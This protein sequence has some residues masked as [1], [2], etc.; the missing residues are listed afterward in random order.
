MRHGVSAPERAIWGTPQVEVCFSFTTMSS[1]LQT[2]IYSSGSVPW[3]LLLPCHWPSLATPPSSNHTSL[4]CLK[5]SYPSVHQAL[6]AVFI[7]VRG[8][9]LN[10]A[11]SFVSSLSSIPKSNYFNLHP[12]LTHLCFR[13]MTKEEE[14]GFFNSFIK[15]PI[16]KHIRVV[17]FTC[18]LWY[19][20]ISRSPQGK[21]N[22]GVIKNQ[23]LNKY[24][25][26]TM[27]LKNSILKLA[28]TAGIFWLHKEDLVS[29][30]IKSQT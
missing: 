16:P 20:D 2:A 4:P 18:D 11:Y 19:T 10:L 14:P 7:A 15:K 28:R 13:K 23:P 17:N 6:S 29:L 27:R 8:P 3:S 1:F 12:I 5:V 21:K 26:S 30:C 25:Y 24:C 9:S 22:T